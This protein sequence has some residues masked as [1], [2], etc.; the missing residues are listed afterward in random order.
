MDIATIIEAVNSVGFPIIACLGIAYFAYKL[1]L[2]MWEK[3]SQTLDELTKTNKV[4]ADTNQLIANKV[5]IAL[6]KVETDVQDI[7][8]KVNDIAYELK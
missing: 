5:E 2:K 4:L 1:F 8:E 7:K 3:V 6:Q